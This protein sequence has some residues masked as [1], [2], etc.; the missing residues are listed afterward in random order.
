[1]SCNLPLTAESDSASSLSS[2]SDSGAV[3]TVA[4][5]RGTA[6]PSG[7]VRAG[8]RKLRA[9]VSDKEKDPEREKLKAVKKRK[10]AEVS[11]CYTHALLG[12]K[13]GPI[14]GTTLHCCCFSAKK[15]VLGSIFRGAGGW[16]YFWGGGG[17]GAAP[18]HVQ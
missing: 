14:G 18:L 6:L 7:V 3:A 13:P 8:A 16:N 10:A 1:M 15:W 12:C 5:G 11:H 9:R 17:K 4:P 2:C